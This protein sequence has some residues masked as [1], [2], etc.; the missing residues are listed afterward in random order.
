MRIDP[1]RCVRNGISGPGIESFIEDILLD[2]VTNNQDKLQAFAKKAITVAPTQELVDELTAEIEK[3][4]AMRDAV[5]GDRPS[6][7]AQRDSLNAS[8]ATQREELAG[9]AADKY[10]HAVKSAVAFSGANDFLEIW[11]SDD[12]VATIMALKTIIKQ[13]EI[14]PSEDGKKLNQWDLKRLGWKVNLTRIRIVWADGT[15]TDGRELA[16]LTVASDA[17]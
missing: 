3:T 7:K 2:M 6:D 17:Q 15:V 9:L 4:I 13:I 1:A 5:V 8:I 10:Q 14:H 12:R 11:N 16:G